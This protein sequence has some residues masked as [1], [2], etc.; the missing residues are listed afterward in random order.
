MDTEMKAN[1]N[2]LSMAYAR[3]RE[4]SNGMHDTIVACDEKLSETLKQFD[5]DVTM[6]TEE[7]AKRKQEAAT[8]AE[9]KRTEISNLHAGDADFISLMDQKVAEIKDIFYMKWNALNSKKLSKHERDALKKIDERNQNYAKQLEKHRKEMLDARDAL[10]AAQMDQVAQELSDEI[11]GIENAY[12]NNMNALNQRFDEKLQ[13]Y[14]DFVSKWVTDVQPQELKKMYEMVK[15]DQPVIANFQYSMNMPEYIQL[16]QLSQLYRMDKTNS[17]KECAAEKSD[18]F[19]SGIAKKLDNDF[20][21]ARTRMDNEYQFPYAV[22]LKDNAFNHIITY[23]A[24]NPENRRAALDYLNAIEALLFMKI[25]NSMIRVS[26]IDPLD[27]A[28]NFATFAS[29]GDMVE[30]T[31]SGGI[32]TSEMEI[33]DRISALETEIKHINTNYL[34]GGLQSI[35]E[36]NE[37][38]DRNRKALHFLFIA[39]FPRGFDNYA[40]DNLER[41]VLNG[42][43]CGIFTFIVA[44]K[45]D[46]HD[47]NSTM[48]S[49]LNSA[50][51]STVE[52]IANHMTEICFTK[53]LFGILNSRGKGFNY[54]VFP[55][56]KPEESDWQTIKERINKGIK[57]G[58]KEHDAMDITSFDDIS[59]E[60][61]QHPE[62]WFGFD[63]S[64]GMEIPIG[65]FGIRKNL[66]ISLGGTASVD[67]HV[68]I[69]GMIGSGKSVLLDTFL[70]MAVMKYSPEELEIYY[71]DMKEGVSSN[72]F[73][74]NL[75]PN[76]KVISKTTDPEYGRMILKELVKVAKQRAETLKEENVTII[77]NIRKERRKKTPRIFLVVDECQNLFKGSNEDQKKECEELL[78]K[79]VKEDRAYGIHVI[80]ASQ[81]LPDELKEAY[82]NI[83]QKILLK[84]DENDQCLRYFVNSSNE[85]VYR[86]K[87]RSMK[88]GQALY[89][90]EIVNVAYKDRDEMNHLLHR[91][92]EKQCGIWGEENL[93]TPRILVS[94]IGESQ[95]NPIS[96][97]VRNG[98]VQKENGLGCPMYL[99][100]EISTVNG[101]SLSMR[102][103]KGHNLLI[104][105]EKEEKA[106]DVMALAALS[107]LYNIFCKYGREAILASKMPVITLFEFRSKEVRKKT[108]DPLNRLAQAFPDMFRIFDSEGVC[109]GVAKLLKEINEQGDEYSER[110]HYVFFAGLNRAK[111]LLDADNAFAQ[112]PKQM[113]ETIVAEGP[114]KGWHF[115]V[116]ANSP[117]DLGAQY[118]N[119]IGSFYFKLCSNLQDD[120]Y[121][122]IV[123]SKKNL[124]AD[125]G[126]GNMVYADY[127]SDPMRIKIYSTPS[128]EWLDKFV[129]R[130]KENGTDQDAGDYEGEFDE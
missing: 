52:N 69:A 99:G 18:A 116:W 39:D 65:R 119:I 71:L 113:F 93:G 111:A 41:V 95:D 12:Q 108:S 74:D 122:S 29:L 104:V 38:Q 59:E 106:N 96:T 62:K 43:R 5:D 76:F 58:A 126:Y 67:H 66:N 21:F 121:E 103:A 85:D 102:P 129:K 24:G 56:K 80:L 3:L 68:A 7:C 107:I 8:A 86:Q 97:F 87:L 30:S 77:D 25:E 70:T 94:K 6:T 28:R 11:K 92:R 109:E 128:N 114:K 53:P 79:I 35:M 55:I 115:I 63:P 57:E 73:A 22:S 40:L 36:Y 26:M 17:C 89:K 112:A 48:N 10:K 13:E 27:S 117:L 101:F 110:D 88:T 127:E 60:L 123:R 91:I 61:E 51:N 15:A 34:S 20:S 130:V 72:V 78:V 23:D 44:N 81:S 105:E 54:V 84:I 42:P 46:V 47:L 118:G 98:I 31:I 32:A 100:E 90:G 33:S 2:A 125:E 124:S 14:A 16:G 4:V 120:E 37:K 1:E 75:I 50:A 64:D 82:T 19:L 45:A 49:M 83:S 9:G